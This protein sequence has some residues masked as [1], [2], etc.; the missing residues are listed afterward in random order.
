MYTTHEIAMGEHRAW[1]EHT[2]KDP[3]KHLLIFEAGAEPLGFVNLT[4]LNAHGIADWGFYVAA[5]SPKGTG[6]KLG[7]AAL[8]YAFDTLGL[9]KVC[10]QAL[11]FNER[12]IKFHRRLGFQSEGVLRDQHFDGVQYH[13][14]VTFGILSHEW[15]ALQKVG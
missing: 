3:R 2:S 7:L 10:G 14:I 9:Y 11:G 12:S 8:S 6:F 15:K 1:F 13:S 5:D 4:E